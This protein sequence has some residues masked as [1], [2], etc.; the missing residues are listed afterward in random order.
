MTKREKELTL[1]NIELRKKII[2]LQRD[3]DEWRGDTQFIKGLI[4]EM[5]DCLHEPG[6]YLQ[7]W[8]DNH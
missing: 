4:I 1:E 7:Y 5:I 2:E 8:S 6:Q 3:R